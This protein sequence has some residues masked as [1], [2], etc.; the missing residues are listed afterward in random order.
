MA[1]NSLVD[2]ALASGLVQPD[3]TTCGSCVLV[4]A[5][6]LNDPA[7][8]GFLVNGVNPASGER[9]AGTVQD[10]FSQQALAMHRL[11]SRFKDTAG[12]WQLPWPRALGTPPW[13]LAREMTNEAGQS[14]TTYRARTVVPNRRAQMF[15]RIAAL[16]GAGHAVPLYVGNRWSPRHVVLVLPGVGLPPGHVRIYDPASGR[17]YPIAAADFAAGRLQVAGWQVPWAVVVPS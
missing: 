17:C 16:A 2:V 14:G 9:T 4:M 3:Q 8:V 15:R 5:R 13:A 12:G 11:T 7:Y 6:M 1:D 10:R